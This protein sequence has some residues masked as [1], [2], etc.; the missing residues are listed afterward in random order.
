MPVRHLSTA[1][2]AAIVGCH[3]NTVRLYEAWGFLPPVRR[4]PK[5]YRLYTSDHLDQMILARTALNSAWPGKNIRRS[6]LALVRHAAN[7][8]LRGALE[9]AYRHLALVQAEQAQAD[10]AVHLVERWIAGAPVHS[11]RGD[12]HIADAAHLLGLSS[13]MLRNWERDGLLEVPR[14]PGNGYRLYGEAEI[15]RLRVIRMLR[16][17]G[18]SSMSILRM[19]SQLDR[20]GSIDPRQAL[21][22]PEGDEDIQH[23]TDRW[24]STLQDQGQ[25]AL[26]I[27]RIL[28]E[29]VRSMPVP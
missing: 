8:D 26:Q 28:E 4:S 6:A 12:L 9:L 20:D 2:I 15:A 10:A 24:L 3:P 7:D 11:D 29:R 1:K 16:S 27:I 14:Q 17:A 5:G 13:D 22:I 21:E 25:R 23:A 19:L 18:Y